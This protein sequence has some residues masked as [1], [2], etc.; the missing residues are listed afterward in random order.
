MINVRTTAPKVPN[1]KSRVRQ[2]SGIF[3]CRIP[4]EPTLFHWLGHERIWRSGHAGLRLTRTVAVHDFDAI[5]GF[6][7]MLAYFL[8]HHDGAMLSAG[9]SEGDGQVALSL[10]NVMRKK[11]NQEFGDA[12][13]EFAGLRK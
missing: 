10:V 12:R 11:V 6:T 9:T 7:Q 5:S 1:T 4:F 3:H 8:G 13:D 2:P